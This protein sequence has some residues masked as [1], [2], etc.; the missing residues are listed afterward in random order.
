MSACGDLVRPSL[1]AGGDGKIYALF[2]RA[3][4]RIQPG[5]FQVDKL[6]DTPIPIS[7]GFAVKDGVIYFASGAHLWRF[8]IPVAGATHSSKA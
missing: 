6:A 5:T 3:I 4:A 7:A 8:R 1:L 2:S